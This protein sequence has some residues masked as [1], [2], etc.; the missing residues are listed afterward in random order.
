MLFLIV[1]MVEVIYEELDISA[2]VALIRELPSNENL[3]GTPEESVLK[4]SKIRN[5]VVHT[6]IG[7]VEDTEFN[8]MWKTLSQVDSYLLCVVELISLHSNVC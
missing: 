8:N 5:K 6:N 1:G 3:K 7:K 4:I 2:I